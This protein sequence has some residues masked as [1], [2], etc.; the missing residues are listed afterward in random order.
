M[1]SKAMATH[2]RYTQKV[3][4]G[5]TAASELPDAIGRLGAEKAS[6][7]KKTEEGR[8]NSHFF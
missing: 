2:R 5:E 7:E 6:L 1:A 8:W 4:P 3:R